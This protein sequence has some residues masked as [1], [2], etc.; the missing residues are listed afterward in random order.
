MAQNDT[1]NVAYQRGQELK[2]TKRTVSF[3]N[4]VYQF[5]NITGFSAGELG[6]INKIMLFISLFFILTFFPASFAAL[7]QKQIEI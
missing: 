4:N 7:Y 2:I 6:S 3:R 1:G 5:K